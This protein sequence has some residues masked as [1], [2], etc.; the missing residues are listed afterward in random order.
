M[1]LSD[2]KAL[3]VDA[4][5]A[6]LGLQRRKA[7]GGMGPALGG[8]VVGAVAGSVGALLLAPQS[9]AKFRESLRTRLMAEPRHPSKLLDERVGPNG[10]H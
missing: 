9:G 5:L 7:A 8:L 10:G 3:D 4:V 6:A 1:Q 2:L